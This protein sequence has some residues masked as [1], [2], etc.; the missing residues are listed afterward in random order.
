[1]KVLSNK[2]EV[3]LGIKQSKSSRSP[4]QTVSCLLESIYHQ[5][6]LLV[7]RFL[8]GIR[9]SSHGEVKL[10][11]C[12]MLNPANQFSSCLLAGSVGMASRS[13]ESP[14]DVLMPNGRRT[15]VKYSS[16]TLTLATM[17]LDSHPLN[18]TIAS[19]RHKIPETR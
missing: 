6:L 9:A 14:H 2:L 18:R 5:S 10:P 16:N 1:M 4:M 3:K 8:V 11:L 12:M 15:C 7:Q 19:P 17:V 13:K